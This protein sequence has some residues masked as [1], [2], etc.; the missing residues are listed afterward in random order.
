MFNFIVLLASI[1]LSASAPSDGY[2]CSASKVDA[3]DD[4][5]AQSTRV[6]MLQVEMNHMAS[7][8]QA[9][10]TL[11]NSTA[12]QVLHAADLKINSN[13]NFTVSIP[14]TKHTPSTDQGPD[15][16]RFIYLDRH[17]L[18]CP[19]L[20]AMSRWKLVRD[21]QT[22]IHFDYT[23]GQVAAIAHVGVAGASGSVSR[24]DFTKWKNEGKGK[25]SKLPKLREH[26]VMCKEKELLTHWHLQRNGNGKMRMEYTCTKSANYDVPYTCKQHTTGKN[27]EGDGTIYLDRHD[28]KCDAGYKLKGWEYSR[29]VKGTFEILYTCCMVKPFMMTVDQSTGPTTQGGPSSPM[30]YL[31]RHTLECPAT[32][33]MKEWK[34]NRPTSSTLSFAYKCALIPDCEPDR[35]TET[36]ALEEGQGNLIYLDRANTECRPGEVLRKWE[37][38][39][40]PVNKYKIHYSCCKPRTALGACKDLSTTKNSDGGGQLIYLDR[41]NVQCPVGSAM[42]KWNFERVGHSEFHINYRCCESSV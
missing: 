27:S 24:D 19:P 42:N 18:Q 29:V 12:H 33:A 41:H 37:Y 15:N 9:A 5:V 1:S 32:T 23:C 4:S 40:V 14:V 39:R 26:P 25:Y 6:Q 16:G 11:S 36:P 34:L 13:Y 21:G 35:D 3:D 8:G 2:T 20:T 22:K 28:V 7:T 30:Y 38:I 31:D 10:P 17:N